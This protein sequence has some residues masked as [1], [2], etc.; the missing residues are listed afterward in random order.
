MLQRYMQSF[1]YQFKIDIYTLF[2][3]LF[4]AF[5]KTML[6]FESVLILLFFCAVSIHYSPQILMNDNS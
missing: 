2:I 6:L 1:I 5:F 3:V 4:I